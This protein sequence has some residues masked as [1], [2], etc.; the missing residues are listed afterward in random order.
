MTC[1]TSESNLNLSE[2]KPCKK[3][4]ATIELSRC[5]LNYKW[6]HIYKSRIRFLIWYLE[7]GLRSVYLIEAVL[8]LCVCYNLYNCCIITTCSWAQVRRKICDFSR[9]IFGDKDSILW[10]TNWLYGSM[11]Q[12]GDVISSTPHL[13]VSFSYWWERM[14]SCA[15]Q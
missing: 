4:R 2:K 10:Q 11:H 1:E 6:M 14:C 8:I 7:L 15:T 3:W 13:P 12:E 9:E 5:K